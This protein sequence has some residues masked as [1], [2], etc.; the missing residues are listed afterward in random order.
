MPVDV[1][2]G[3]MDPHRILPLGKLPV[4]LLQSLLH[5]MPSNDPRVLLGP[6]IGMDCAVIDMGGPDLLVVK[7][8]PI[9]FAAEEIGWYAVQIN[10]ND[11]ATTGAVPRW[12]LAT[13]LLPERKT[14]PTLVEQI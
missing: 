7:S 8:D 12:M 10:A 6:G 4:E 5:G 2:I 14:T 1:M 9:T 3:P 11:I 13:A